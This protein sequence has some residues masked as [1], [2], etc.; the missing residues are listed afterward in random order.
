MANRTDESERLQ[1]I[2]YLYRSNLDEISKSKSRNALLNLEVIH[3]SLVDLSANEIN[4]SDEDVL[5]IDALLKRVEAIR[6][7]KRKSVNVKRISLLTAAL[8]TTF[9]LVV[10]SIISNQPNFGID[11]DYWGSLAS[12]IGLVLAIVLAI[13]AVFNE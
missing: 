11:I 8:L 13:L 4:L 9:A 3:H 2:I 6:K 7:V 10:P 12:I 1:D 5:E